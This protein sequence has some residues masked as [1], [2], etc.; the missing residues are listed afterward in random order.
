MI[1]TSLIWKIRNERELVLSSPILAGIVNYTDNSFVN[2]YSTH[3]SK[4]LLT[5]I[6]KHHQEGATIIDLGAE[7]TKPSATPIDPLLEKEKLCSILSA[8]SCF[9]PDYIFSIDTYKASVASAVLEYRCDIINDVTGF[10]Y[11]A[12][13]LDVLCEYKPGYVLT[14]STRYTNNTTP[15]IDDII[16][17]FEDKMNILIKKGLPEEYIV[18]DIGIGF[19]YTYPYSLKIIKDIK[20]LSCF[21]RPLFLGISHKTWYQEKTNIS[22]QEKEIATVITTALLAQVIHVHRV[23]NVALA[24]RA[25]YIAKQLE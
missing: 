14:F 18:L 21:N 11:D 10:Q 19:G 3:S 5:L 24:K 16:R 17:Y 23:H 15:T 6:E 25:L 22:F 2:Q 12:H 8:C 20:A 7:S 9:P 4:D 1:D 13:L